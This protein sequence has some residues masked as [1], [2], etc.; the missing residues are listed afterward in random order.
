MTE[1]IPR[2]D[3]PTRA[4]SGLTVPYASARR[5]DPV[6]RSGHTADCRLRQLRV[7]PTCEVCEYAN[8]QCTY[9]PYVP[10]VERGTPARPGIRIE[11]TFARQ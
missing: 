10:P 4:G 7:V 11:K 2:R 1:P 9:Q 3:D 8:G 5:L 6:S